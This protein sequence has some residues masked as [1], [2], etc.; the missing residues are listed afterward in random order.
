MK[1]NVITLLL[2]YFCSVVW[3]HG[4]DQ[5]FWSLPPAKTVLVFAPHP[6][7]ELIGCGG[8]I[9][10][11]V[12]EGARVVIVYMTSGEAAEWHGSSQELSLVREQEARAASE[13]IGVKDIDFLREPDGALIKTEKVIYEV[14][15][16][17]LKYLPEVIYV[18]HADE[19]HKD[20]QATFQ[21]ITAAQQLL[22]HDKMPLTLCYEVWTPLQRFTHA[23][24]IS[25]ALDLKL[26]ALSEYRSQITYIDYR[27]GVKGLNRYRGIMTTIGAYVECFQ[28]FE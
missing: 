26:E 8:S 19:E 7:D 21:I 17:L 14:K 10:Q 3:C 4:Y 24:N 18:P 1:K 11:Y 9:I 16:L 15:D 12:R 27:D 5:D 20:H 2:L 23:V 13:K 6:D 25:Q 28:K 22:V